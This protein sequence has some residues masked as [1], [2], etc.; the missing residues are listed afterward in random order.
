MDY[1]GIMYFC[2]YYLLSIFRVYSYS[3]HWRKNKRNF[4]WPVWKH[5]WTRMVASYL[6]ISITS[7]SY[8]S[9]LLLEP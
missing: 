4:A 5:T 9:Y 8:K 7:R 3:R 6:V 2:F 1:F